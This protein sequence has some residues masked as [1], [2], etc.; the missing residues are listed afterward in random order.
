MNGEVEQ[1]QV[2]VLI[3]EDDESHL[4]NFKEV[5]D[6]LGYNPVTATNLQ[7][8]LDLLSKICFPVALVDLRLDEEDSNN[9]DGFKVLERIR[10][11]N[12]GTAMIVL[13]AYGEVKHAS[14]GFRKYGVKHF[15]RK[16]EIDWDEVEEE[17]RKAVREF[18]WE[19]LAS[20]FGNYIR[21]LT[22]DQIQKGLAI[23]SFEE[24][25]ACVRR[26]FHRLH[27]LL[28]SK[29]DAR[30]V[31]LP[32]GVRALEAKAWSRAL[33]RP[34]LMR[35]GSRDSIKNWTVEVERSLEAMQEAGLEERVREVDDRLNLPHVAAVLYILANE[36][37][38][39]FIAPEYPEP[40][41]WKPKKPTI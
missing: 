19:K 17:I 22:I 26:L 31:E 32:D 40:V 37:F 10:D 28:P 35:L 24:I 3:V 27:P 13:T 16:N 41:G 14:E 39:N 34:V 12:E 33:G 38:E 4:E 18:P 23:G 25:D 29:E 21:G 9:W 7:E 11:I 5:V 1:Q 30:I 15:V 6:G 2:N 36:P 20:P 8:A